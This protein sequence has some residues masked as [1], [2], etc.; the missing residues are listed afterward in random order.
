M[1]T[2]I[3]ILFMLAVVLAIAMATAIVIENTVI[4]P[5]IGEQQ[6]DK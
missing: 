3:T 4:D 5:F 6:L 2:T 1:K